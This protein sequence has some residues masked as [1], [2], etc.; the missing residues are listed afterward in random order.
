MEISLIRGT[1]DT[2]ESMSGWV[3]TSKEAVA[4]GAEDLP[5]QKGDQIKIT[6]DVYRKGEF[7]G[8]IA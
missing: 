1:L 5:L 2:N 6:G 3:I 4:A 8:N 7:I